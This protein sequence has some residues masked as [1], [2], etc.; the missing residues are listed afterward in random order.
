MAELTQE[1]LKE[2]A[3]QKGFFIGVDSDGCAFDTMEI[4]HK[5]CFIPNII[6]H[7]ELQPVS[8]YA[9]EAAEFVNLYS[10]WRGINRFPALIMV[11]DLLK[12]RPEVLKRNVSIPEVKSLR[13]WVKSE[14]KLGNPALKEAV[15]KTGDPILKKALAWS[16]A[17]NRTVAD[18][19]KGIPPFPF[20]Q[21]SLE[22]AG[23]FADIIVVSATPSEALQREWKEHGIDKY[24]RA[25]CGQ[26][27]GKKE[28]HIGLAARG[29]YKSEHILMI[30]DAPGDM[31]AAKANG[32]LFYPIIPGH[33]DESWERFF[34]EAMEKFFKGEYAGTYEQELIEEFDRYLPSTP[35]WE[36]K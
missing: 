24:V 10:K 32:A 26:E 1:A 29:K 8:K 13:E 19:V 23:E 17:V 14:T 11:F 34:K 33:E 30:G 20:V 5:E 36:S 4:K 27:L 6:K 21:E 2:M 25:I 7:W 3:P 15:E 16:E 22:K 31:K 9:R 12:E 18:M 28:E 35:P